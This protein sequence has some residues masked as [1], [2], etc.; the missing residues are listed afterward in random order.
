LDDKFP[1]LKRGARWVD[2]WLSRL[3]LD[4]VAIERGVT[5]IVGVDLSAGR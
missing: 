5:E 4:P 3:A 2:L 1:L